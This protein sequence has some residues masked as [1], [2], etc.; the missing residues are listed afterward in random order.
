MPKFLNNIDLN[1]NQLL[2]PVIHPHATNN[3][4]HGPSNSTAGIA[5]QI[6]Y[7]SHSSVKALYFNDGS[8]WRP[9]GDITGV[10]LTTDD[11]ATISDTAGSAAFTI[12]GGSGI[13]TSSTGSTVTITSD[14]VTSLGT[15]SQDSVLFTSD[16]SDDPLLTIENT[17]NDVNGA[18]LLFKKDKGAAG[19]DGDEI[20]EIIFTGDNAAQEQTNYAKI[21]TLIS[22][23][24]DGTEGG[25]F[26]VRI[27]THDGE[28]Q[29]GLVLE[30]GDAEDEID[31]TIGRGS[32]SNTTI[33]GN[34]IVSGDT[35]SA[36]VGTLDVEDKN[37]TLNKSDSDSSST[38]DGA[39]ITIQDAVDAS[40]DAS[41]LWTASSDTFT[42]SHPIN[43]NVTGALT[44]NASTATTA[45]GLSATLIVGQG[46]TG[47]STFTSKAVLLGNGTSGINELTVGSAGQVLTIDSGGNPVFA[48]NTG[49]VAAAT[50]IVDNQAST[51]ATMFLVLNNVA[52]DGNAHSLKT[53]ANATYSQESGV[54]T[55][56]GFVGSL[57]GAVT[58]NA[59]TA[60]LATTAT[61]VTVADES[62]DTSC[63]VLFVTAATG[64]LPPKSGTNL[65]FN[66]NTGILTATG[67]SGP[68]TGAVTGNASTAT[69]LAA[70]TTVAV[71]VGTVELGHATDTTIARSAAGKATI[72]GNLIGVVKTFTLN[73]TGVVQSNND[74]AASTVFTIT[75][76]M[77][78][79]RFYKVEVVLNSG[80][81]DT[82]FADIARPSAST[83]T[84]TFAANVALGAYA[85]MVTRMA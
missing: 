43:A 69:N 47:R 25:K 14:T 9:I 12:A 46:G 22:T 13:T 85:A 5:G 39:G 57:T 79:S 73:D 36:N 55:A 35:I 83:I 7:N 38:A 48:A 19:A 42:F 41:I 11:N 54:I 26:E 78:D 3:T 15:I 34:L 32:A 6:F 18:R 58:G 8:N 44:G 52:G 49:S 72:E 75:H 84:V 63:N 80:D 31:V 81:Y 60:T 37:I 77:G 70:N 29:P 20:G 71:P 33:L 64:N 10:A 59:S 1:G 74:A 23:A 62:T 53:H 40:N 68:L 16:Q 67:F 45:A 76:G 50:V 17:S 27:A 65:T 2:S 66:S 4:T 28:M 56:Q 51:D 24:A 82:V 61:N 21:R 30:D